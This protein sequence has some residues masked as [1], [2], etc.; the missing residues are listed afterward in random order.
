MAA[1]FFRAHREQGDPMYFLN[2]TSG[3]QSRQPLRKY[4][5]YGNPTYK[6]IVTRIH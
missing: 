1:E 5:G 2:N 4:V 6:A 3:F